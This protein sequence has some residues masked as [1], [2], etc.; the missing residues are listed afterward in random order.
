[1]CI[2]T[3]TCRYATDKQC[4]YVLACC[5]PPCKAL[6]LES[7]HGPSLACSS[8]AGSSMLLLVSGTQV[9]SHRH[10]L[11]SSTNWIDYST[12]IRRLVR[13]HLA[14]RALVQTFT[15]PSPLHMGPRCLMC[16]S[17]TLARLPILPPRHAPRARPLLSGIARSTVLA[18][19]ISMQVTVLFPPLWRRM[20]I[21]AS[22][23]WATSGRL[24]LLWPAAL[25][26]SPGALFL[27]VR[28]GSLVLH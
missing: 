19:V 15:Q 21:W 7:L 13:Q 14:N 24:V 25:W 3:V 26:V 2:A 17:S 18:L 12:Y 4:W 28:T 1:M 23:F 27:P 22:R 9:A 16:Q 5:K 20:A 10:V 8:E 11:P 6:D